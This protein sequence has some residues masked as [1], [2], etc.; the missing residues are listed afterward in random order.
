MSHKRGAESWGEFVIGLKINTL[1]EPMVSVISNAPL[2]ADPIPSELFPN[3][4]L[5]TLWHA[6]MFP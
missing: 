1:L 4:G 6:P 3:P 2:D 5:E